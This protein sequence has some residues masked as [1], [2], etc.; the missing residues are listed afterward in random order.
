MRVGPESG[1]F[2]SPAAQN[3]CQALY[4]ELSQR[5]CFSVLKVRPKM[6]TLNPLG[7]EMFAVL[8]KFDAEPR[9][10]VVCGRSGRDHERSGVRLLKDDDV[11][12]ERR[13]FFAN[14]KY[15]RSS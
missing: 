8:A 15:E 9:S 1:P 13:Y 5:F 3:G 10:C 11:A 7:C 2:G 4:S 12:A 14:G 6:E